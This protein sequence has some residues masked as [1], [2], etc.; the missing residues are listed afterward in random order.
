[1]IWKNLNA[2]TG[3]KT[4]ELPSEGIG[5]FFNRTYD[6]G[7]TGHELRGRR[8]RSLAA[9]NSAFERR[10]LRALFQ[11]EGLQALLASISGR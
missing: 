2:F 11:K 7:S 3:W 5:F 1:M 9:W 6:R 4:E 10:S 8:Q